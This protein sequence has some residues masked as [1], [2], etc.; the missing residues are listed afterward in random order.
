MDNS[1]SHNHR[2]VKIFI[3]LFFQFYK[4]LEKLPANILFISPYSYQFNPIE[5]VFGILE[6]TYKK[7]Y[8]YS[9]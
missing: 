1:G 2:Y 6:N 4:D 7:K 9:Y 5:E 8:G 3:I